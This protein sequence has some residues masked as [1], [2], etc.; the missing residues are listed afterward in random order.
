MAC[1]YVD[2]VSQIPLAPS[3]FGSLNG[4]QLLSPTR[5]RLC[6]L[7]RTQL[8][9]SIARNTNVVVALKNELEVAK[10]ESGRLAEFCET[11]GRDNDLINEVIS[12]LEEC[13]LGH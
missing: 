3:D 4:T 8:I 6:F 12:D 7:N 10:F 11:A 9:R 13:L 5:S 2:P 1:S